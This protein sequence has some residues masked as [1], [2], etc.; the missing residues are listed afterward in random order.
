M[1]TEHEVRVIELKGFGPHPNADTLSITSIEGR[2]V[3]FKTGDFNK[4]DKVVYIQSTLWY[5]DDL[6]LFRKGTQHRTTSAVFVRL[7][8]YLFYGSTGKIRSSVGGW[9]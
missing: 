9:C 1:S 5:A 6:R 4:G 8:L 7:V 2:P 3:I